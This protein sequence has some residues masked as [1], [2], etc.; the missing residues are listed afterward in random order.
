MKFTIAICT[1]NRAPLLEKTLQRLA[2]V[3]AA[4]PHLPEVEVV[5]VNNNSRDHTDE[6]IARMA[7]VLPLRRVFQSLQGLSHARN[8]AVEAAQGDFILWTDDDVL[9]DDGWVQ[10]YAQGVQAHPKALV[11]GGPVRP[12]FEAPPPQWLTDNWLALANAYAV[13][14]LGDRLIPLDIATGAVPFGANYGVRTDVQRKYLYDP[15]LGKTGNVTLLG[16]ESVVIDAILKNDGPGY[17]LPAAQVRHWV[18]KERMEEAYIRDYFFGAGR[19]HARVDGGPGFGV[20]MPRWRYR[21]MAEL[22]WAQFS[23]RVLGRADYMKRLSLYC[24]DQ[25]YRS[26]KRASG[27]VGG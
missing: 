8:A 21:R 7:A 17:W 10:A 15:K 13:R 11:F 6:V 18:P 1:Y 2:D 24:Y 5:V 27:L 23:A 9:V 16:E 22:W 3:L 14:D 4:D 26:E 19:T 20:L 12:W 25:G